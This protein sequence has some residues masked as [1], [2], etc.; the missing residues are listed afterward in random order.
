[1][2][3]TLTCRCGRASCPCTSK[4]SRASTTGGACTTAASDAE[5]ALTLDGEPREL[6]RTEHAGAV[7]ERSAT[8]S[9]IAT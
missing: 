3:R 4:R 5:A 7:A 2:R 1:M 8:I 6:D 9:G